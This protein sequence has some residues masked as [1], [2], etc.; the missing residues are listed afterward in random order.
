[1]AVLVTGAAGFLGMHVALRL[2]KRG[3]RVIG[4]DNLNDYYSLELKEARLCELEEFS[5]FSFHYLDIG[6]PAATA[7]VFELYPDLTAVV[8]LA[9]QVG[10]GHSLRNPQAFLQTNIAG[11]FV[12]LEECRKLPNLEHVVYGSSSAVYGGNR[13][14]PFAE[15]DSAAQP[16]SVYAASKRADELLAAAYAHLYNIPMTGLRLFAIYGPWGRPDMFY[17][18]YSRAILAGE[19]IKVYNG[20]DFRRDFTYVDD[21]VDG[22]LAALDKPAVAPSPMQA[23]HLILNIG[24][25][26]ADSLRD[27]IHEIEGATGRPAIIENEPMKPDDLPET[28]ADITVARQWIGF[29]PRTTLSEGIQGF[30]EWYHNYHL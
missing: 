11:M 19:P 14:V 25:D 6:D 10:V 18:S 13:K 15:S 24:N 9:A 23:P 2:L 3:E 29:A 28:Y 21:A 4:V 20:G 27:F 16:R 26:H 7:A 12:L 1:M 5:N 17:Y 8:H 22:L 30:L